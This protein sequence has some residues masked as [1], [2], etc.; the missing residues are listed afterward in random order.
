MEETETS[1]SGAGEPSPSGRQADMGLPN[2]FV[3]AEPFE[4]AAAGEEQVRWLLE[5]GTPVLPRL[6]TVGAGAPGLGQ[7]ME[8]LR[9]V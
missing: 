7:S 9:D 2:P 4:G 8:A 5:E 3:C 1:V 6:L